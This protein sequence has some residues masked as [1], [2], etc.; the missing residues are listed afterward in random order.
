MQV[1]L[2]APTVTGCVALGEPLNLLGLCVLTGKPGT[3]IRVVLPALERECSDGAGLAQLDSLLNPARVH[4][5][6]GEEPPGRESLRTVRIPS[7][8]CVLALLGVWVSMLGKVKKN[9]HHR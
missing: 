3:G 4:M 8:L 9:N 2:Q 6:L 1:P 5:K 7:P